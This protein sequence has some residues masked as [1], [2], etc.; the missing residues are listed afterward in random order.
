MG[1][2]GGI[3]QNYRKV[4]GKS[5]QDILDSDYWDAKKKMTRDAS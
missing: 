3:M 5:A 2:E 1:V 4:S